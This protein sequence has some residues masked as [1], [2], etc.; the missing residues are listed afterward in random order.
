MQ[1]TEPLRTGD[2]SR[3]GVYRLTGLLG[4]GGQ[5]AV[6]RGEAPDG[7]QV[8]VK[9]LHARFRGDARA[10]ARFAAELSHAERVAPFCTARVLDADLDGDQPYIVSEFVD[11]PPLAELITTGGASQGP[12]LERIAIAT[13]TA[14][15]AIHE[16]GIVHRDFKPGN[17]IMGADGP[18]VIDFGI[19]RALDATGT[20]SSGV[21]GTP[22]YMAPEQIAGGTPGPATDVFAWGCTIAYA[23]SGVTPFGQ[24]SIPAVMHRILHEEPDLSGLTAPLRDTVSAC[25]DKDPARRPTARQVLLRLLGAEDTAP[26]ET[27][28]G[29][30]ARA[31]S[32]PATLPYGAEPVN[33]PYGADARPSAPVAGP[34]GARVPYGPPPGAVGSTRADDPGPGRKGRR[35]VTLAA[36]IAAVLLGL[37]TLLPW[38]RVGVR[39]VT[40]SGAGHHT[41]DDA[42]VHGVGTLWGVLVLIMAVIV[43]NLAIIEAFARRLS[44]AWAAVPGGIAVLSIVV[45]VLR[46]ADLHGK[47]PHYGR[48]SDA[49]LRG[50]GYAFQITLEPGVFAA[51]ALAVAITALSVVSLT[52]TARRAP[53]RVPPPRP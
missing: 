38:G 7:A 44:A 16:A 2:P 31:T 22:A 50:I 5:G 26:A 4:E 35:V 52:F 24:D 11:G 29:A 20:L 9:L 1:G 14:L 21:V 10:R 53:G 28:L 8:A 30:G 19:A 18:R 17:V 51:L 41:F 32:V 37:T 3:V 39:M 33:G 25:L 13:I 43:V 34:H 42:G 40:S 6:Y 15:T 48:L 46:K 45:F 49:E 47:H 12:A 36:G 27:L 23:S